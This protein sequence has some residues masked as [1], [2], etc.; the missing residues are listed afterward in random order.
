M[1]SLKPSTPDDGAK[2]RSSFTQ[3]E[4][5]APGRVEMIEC[6][7]V[8]VDFVK[9]TVDVYSSYDQRRFF[10]IQVGSP[11]LHHSNGE[12]FSVTPEI[13]AKCM[14]CI[15]GDSSPPHVAYFIMAFENVDLS[16]EEAPQGTS[17]HG[18][19]G[20]KPSGASFAGGRGRGKPGDMT[21]RGRDGNFVTLHRGG[22]LE[23]GAAELCQRVF[24]PLSHT[25]VDFS[26][27]YYHHTQGGTEFWGILPGKDEGNSA[28]EYF[29]TFR[30]WAEN[31]FAD[32]RIK[33][34]KV[35]DPALGQLQ[36][37]ATLKDV[38]Y[39]VTI[40]PQGIDPDSGAFHDVKKTVYRFAADMSGNVV[41]GA[42]NEVTIY[43]T[44]LIRIQTPGDIRATADG[45]VD[46]KGKNG[47]Y[48]DGGAIAH[49]KGGVVRLGPGSKPVATQGS[50]VQ[51]TFPFTPMMSAPIPLALYGVI[52]TG[53]PTVLA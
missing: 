18:V 43:G 14:V 13:H 27:N 12:G 36:G 6:R 52:V 15:P 4:G 38:A 29:Q 9:W 35:G 11:Y 49:I 5:A 42:K 21:L 26:E 39:E 48:I 10:A 25:M 23:I 24:I 16:S 41:F 53:E 37:D 40:A 32:V 51:L 28:T 20:M 7:V 45:V 2:F 17:G 46:I 50:L 34:G 31:K 22:V 33:K 8:N 30:V 19:T 47:A 1:P 44:K 3:K